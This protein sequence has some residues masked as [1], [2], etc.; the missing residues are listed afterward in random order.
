M[1]N[2]FKFI[3]NRKKQYRI[4]SDGKPIAYFDDEIDA[5]WYSA[6]TKSLSYNKGKTIDILKC[7]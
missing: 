4:Y 1:F 5:C 6:I 7:R 2:L 3:K